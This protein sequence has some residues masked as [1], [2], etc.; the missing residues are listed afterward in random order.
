MVKVDPTVREYMQSVRAKRKDYSTS[1]F[2]NPKVQAKIAKIKAEKKKNVQ[3]EVA[4]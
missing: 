4:K 3:P 2:A 1:G